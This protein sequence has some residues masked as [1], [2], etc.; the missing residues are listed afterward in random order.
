MEEGRKIKFFGY[1]HRYYQIGKECDLKFVL[2]RMAVIPDG[3]KLEVS[4]KFESFRP[5]EGGECR[6]SAN[7]WLHNEAL[8]YKSAPN[9]KEDIRKRV[10][11]ECNASKEAVTEFKAKV[12][13]IAPVKKESFL[14]SLLDDVDKNHR[15]AK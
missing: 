13:A 9:Q 6:K 3:K 8:K 7:T 11:I 1:P 15:K 2:S 4:K 10:D 5:W 14:E 12:D